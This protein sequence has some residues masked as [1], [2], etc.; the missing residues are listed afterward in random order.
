MRGE[1]S[2]PGVRAPSGIV[3]FEE[4]LSGWCESSVD[5]TAVHF[6]L[7]P[8]V[9]QSLFAV[10][11]AENVALTALDLRSARLTQRRGVGNMRV[12]PSQLLVDDRVGV[13]VGVCDDL[14]VVVVQWQ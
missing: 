11:L 9:P 5:R 2:R 7:H 1:M 3:R 14:I 8:F 4:L 13:G 6:V 12:T 10:L